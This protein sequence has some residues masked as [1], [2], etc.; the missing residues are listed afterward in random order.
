MNKKLDVVKLVGL[1]GM[2]LAGL[3]TLVSNWSTEKQMEQIINEKV[4]EALALR[5][6]ETE[7]S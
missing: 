7:E 3:A 5:E 1:A 2:A 6:A 4:N